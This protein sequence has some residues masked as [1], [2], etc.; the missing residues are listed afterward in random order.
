MSRRKSSSASAKRSK[1]A[2]AFA[3]GAGRNSHR[4]RAFSTVHGPLH[5]ETLEARCMLAAVSWIGG[6]DNS[7]SSEG[8]WSGGS[9]PGQDDDVT[10]TLSASST[11]A[12][13]GSSVTVKSLDC[14][15]SLS[16][17]NCEMTV[18]QSFDLGQT[19]SLT[20]S[21]SGA[22][23]L[24]SHAVDAN[25]SSF[26]AINGGEIQ[27][28][29]MSNYD[30]GD[31]LFSAQL[32]ASG[33][34][35]LLDFPALTRLVGKYDVGVQGAAFNV[36]NVVASNGGQINLS[37]VTS[38]PASRVGIT[39]SGTGSDVDLD[40]L[41]QITGVASGTNGQSQLEVDGGGMIDVPDLTSVFGV[42][43]IV[44]PDAALSL[45]A[46]TQFSGGDE[47]LTPT[48]DLKA[49]GPNSLLD[50]PA[51]TSLTGKIDNNGGITAITASNGGHINLS[52]VTQFLPSRVNV[53]SSGTGSDVDLSALAQMGGSG[54][55][56]RLEIEDGGTI[57]VPDLANVFGVSLVAG[58]NETLSLPALT[59][60][61]GGDDLRG[62]R[63]DRSHGPA[64]SIRR[65][66]PRDGVRRRTHQS[67]CS[68]CQCDG[69]I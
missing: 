58:P 7:W 10:I 8:N 24:A 62:P 32:S 55:Q 45:P 5:L 56:G 33:S 44:G 43:L 6:V 40:A 52:M 59:S 64:R 50:F 14:Q 35:S 25:G 3:A 42:S 53:L 2:R 20:V 30:G 65:S 38:I 68:D 31:G 63:I 49:T 21:G 36:I 4:R 19:A 39:A 66:R 57:E 9:V 67:Q 13:T 61:D 51:L 37:A 34:G 69:C 1:R 23:F 54:W 12:V 48:T 46:L 15:S 60:F 29:F 28:P 47:R 27:C 18:T 41:T 17:F 22:K 26:L 16:I 11:V